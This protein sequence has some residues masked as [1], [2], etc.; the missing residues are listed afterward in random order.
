MS[1]GVTRSRT[2][3]F[4][5]YRDSAPRKSLSRRFNQNYS[6]NNTSGLLD[7]DE[8][9]ERRELIAKDSPGG[10]IS[11]DMTSPPKWYAFATTFISALFPD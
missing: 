4:F 7:D 11:L 1:P 6:T 8:N 3:L 9:D 10:F 5:S 2:L